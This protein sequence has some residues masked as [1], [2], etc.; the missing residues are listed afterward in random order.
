[1]GVTSLRG[2]LAFLLVSLQN[3]SKRGTLKNRN[4]AWE[5]SGER[6]PVEGRK[7]QGKAA[8]TTEATWLPMGSYFG[9]GAPPIL[10]Y[11]SGDWDVHW[12][13]DPQPC[14]CTQQAQNISKLSWPI[15]P[16]L[17]P[18]QPA[19]LRPLSQHGC[20]PGWRLTTDSADHNKA[21]G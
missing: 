4:I 7:L 2:M 20:A 15:N 8:Q 5:A 11:F 18:A 16:Q 10:V 21:P 19:A 17:C 3:R 12:G 1:M 9:V 14:H 6:G 13:Y